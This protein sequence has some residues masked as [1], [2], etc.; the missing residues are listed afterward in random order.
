[1]GCPDCA[2]WLATAN[3]QPHRVF[4]CSCGKVH[5]AT[6]HPPIEAPVARPPWLWR[7]CA[8]LDIPAVQWVP[9]ANELDRHTTELELEREAREERREVR[10]RN[11]ERRIGWMRAQ[12][13]P[14]AH[15]YAAIVL[16]HFGN[17]RYEAQITP[18]VHIAAKFGIADERR[19]FYDALVYYRHSIPLAQIDAML[20]SAYGSDL[21]LAATLAYEE[22]RWSSAVPFIPSTK[23]KETAQVNTSKVKRRTKRKGLTP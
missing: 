5:T 9:G 2:A 17:A 8:R 3:H 6:K 10:Q 18:A 11:G 7:P 23:P 22:G 4:K 13:D 1:M 14:N 19:A 12:P 20:D 15:R 16:E 21:I